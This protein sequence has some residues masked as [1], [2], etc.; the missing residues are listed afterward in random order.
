MLAAGEEN[1]ENSSIFIDF[2]ALFQQ[3]GI[4][5]CKMHPLK[6]PQISLEGV[7]TPSIT[8]WIHAWVIVS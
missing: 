4:K 5:F 2:R 1:F 6:H 7:R 3:F 8:P